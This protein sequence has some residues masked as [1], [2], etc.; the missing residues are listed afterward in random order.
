MS[1]FFCFHI[2]FHISSYSQGTI[3]L[4]V[5]LK[6]LG[7]LSQGFQCRGTRRASKLLVEGGADGQRRQLPR[8]RTQWRRRQGSWRQ[9]GGSFLGYGWVIGPKCPKDPRRYPK[10]W[11][12]WVW[13]NVFMQFSPPKNA[14]WSWMHNLLRGGSCLWSNKEVGFNQPTS[15]WQHAW[16]KYRDTLMNKNWIQI[17]R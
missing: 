6:K 2:A 10:N 5:G 1:C 13:E 9:Q 15:C 16:K 12:S 14:V 3:F 17:Y 8:R 11:T 7:G 4:R